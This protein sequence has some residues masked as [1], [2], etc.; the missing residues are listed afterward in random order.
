M[1]S[2]VNIS[3]INS[4]LSVLADVL[5]PNDRAGTA[6]L[7]LRSGLNGNF[8]LLPRLK[9]NLLWLQVNQ[10]NFSSSVKCVAVYHDSIATLPG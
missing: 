9:D 3:S 2:A 4:H 7:S 5:A 6:S 1:K 8:Y 10:L